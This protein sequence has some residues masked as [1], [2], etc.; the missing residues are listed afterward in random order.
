MKENPVFLN[1]SDF[2][3]NISMSWE[4]RS[5]NGK[6]IEGSSVGVEFFGEEGSILISGGNE[7]KIFNL[8]NNTVKEVKDTKEID[9]G[10]AAN[11]ASHL[12]A[13]HIRNLFKNILKGEKLRADINSGYKSTLLVQLGNIAQRVGHSLEINTENG[14]IIGD[15]KA[16][17]LWSREYEKG[18]KIKL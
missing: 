7:Y 9:P 15:R 3:N 14:H 8:K 2:E 4:G 6:Y 13:L 5:C 17:K 12:D 18:W 10:D 11:P 1:I 16:K